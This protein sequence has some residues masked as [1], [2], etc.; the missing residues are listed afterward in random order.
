MTLEH[1]DDLLLDALA[2][3]SSA[4]EQDQL[5]GLLAAW[6]DDLDAAPLPALRPAT[7]RD[8][9]ASPVFIPAQ[10]RHPF[11][12]RRVSRPLIVAVAAAVLAFGGLTV[13]SANA[14]PGTPLW[15][16]TRIFF[17][18]T[19][20]SRLTEQEATRL[21][22][23]ARAAMAAGN[24]LKAAEL[25]QAAR[26]QIGQITDN[27]ARQRL[28]AESDALWNQIR[29]MPVTGGGSSTG[30]PGGGTPTPTTSGGGGILPT[31]L[32]TILPSLPLHFR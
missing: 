20:K 1:D 9:V 29:Q 22:D 19:A 21:L 23:Q 15:P 28:T 16:L 32:P 25:V 5:A 31:I 18:D 24:R 4:P 3:G 30:T 2:A 10:R 14:A 26:V 11:R 12:P 17:G 13:A 8:D 7:E 27:E 6:R